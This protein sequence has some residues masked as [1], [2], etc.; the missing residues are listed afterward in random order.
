MDEDEFDEDDAVVLD[1]FD[2]DAAEE[3]DEELVT[4][5]VLVCFVLFSDDATVWSLVGFPN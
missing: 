2:E 5:F 3:V 4:W 1:E